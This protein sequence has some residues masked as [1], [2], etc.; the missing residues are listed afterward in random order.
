M[1]ATIMQ[2]LDTTIANVALPHMQGSMSAT[3]DQISWVLTSYIVAAAIMTPP[4]GVLAAR[5]GRKRLF[6]IMVTGFTLASMLCGAATSLTEIL[7][8]R[9]LQ[10]VFGAGLVPLSQSV[11]LDTF[12]KE[13]HG[14]A[15]AMWGVG[16]MV[17]PILGPTLGGYLTEFYNWRWV[18]YINLPFGILAL[19]GIL[20]FVPETVR[21]RTRS[22][23]FFG[24]ALLSLAIGSM[25]L[26]LDRGQS[27]DWF[28]STEIVIEAVSAALFFYL[29]LVQMFTAR[30]PFLE[31]GLFKDRNLAVGLLLIFV[32]GVILLATLALLPPFLQNL[33]EFPVLTTGFVLAP[34][35][36]GTM[37]AMLIVGRL[38]GKVDTRLLILTGLSLTSLSLWE[39]SLF[40]TD[41]PIATIVR[42]GITQGLGLGFIFVP[43]STTAFSTLAPHYRNEGT[44]MF[45]LMRNIG[46]SVGISIMI[47]LLAQNTQANHAAFADLL[48]PFRD[49]LQFPWLPAAWNWHTT[50]GLAALN[51]EVTRQ[52][53]T[54]AYLGDFRIMMWVTLLAAPLL[55]LLR[56]P[57]GAVTGGAAAVAD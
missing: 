57:P 10:G 46:S 32:V 12:P 30:R 47:T 44:A 56:K 21:D 16:V 26:M 18:F 29:F 43:L 24:F 55:L 48:T 28:N 38:I 7:L 15:M 52:A 9:L 8:F 14:S 51:G 45:S 54:I 53:A 37:M 19:L 2:A 4:T 11:L 5:I 34:R 39:M 40:T 1:L 23:D 50:S 17:G 6:A 42:T 13:K 35:G 33:M 49:T 25:Q 3:Q 41:V 31:P 27:Q 22:F 20:T 36:I